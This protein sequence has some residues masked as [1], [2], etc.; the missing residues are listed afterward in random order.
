VPPPEAEELDG[1]AVTV[2]V[3]GQFAVF[4]EPPQVAD[5]CK[6]LIVCAEVIA[7]LI[8]GVN[9]TELALSVVEPQ[10]TAGRLGV[11]PTVMD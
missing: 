7:F 6:L 8:F 3:P 11:C 2:I 9:V 1:T 10:P 4:V 5:T